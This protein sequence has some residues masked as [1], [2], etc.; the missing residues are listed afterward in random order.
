MKINYLMRKNSKD[1]F[2]RPWKTINRTSWQTMF[3]S[4]FLLSIS[5]IVSGCGMANVV[6]EPLPLANQVNRANKTTNE[7]EIYKELFRKKGLYISQILVHTEMGT[8]ILIH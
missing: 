3:L 6:S 5:Y 4:T 7:I 1:I 2:L 8:Q